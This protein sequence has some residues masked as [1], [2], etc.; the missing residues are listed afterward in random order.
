LRTKSGFAVCFTALLGLSTVCS[1]A[2]FTFEDKATGTPMPF[3]STVSGLTATVSGTGGACAIGFL[4]LTLQSGI[5]AI[6]NLCVTSAL[7]P[8][9]DM[10]FSQSLSAI[11][12]DFS[13][14]DTNAVTM[15]A[16]LGA[17]QIGSISLAGSIPGGHTFPEGI[18]SFNGGTF[19]NV[20][21]TSTSALSI[22]NVNTI[23]TPEPGSLLLLSGGLALLGLARRRRD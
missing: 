16:F 19:D 3:N 12:L 18:L 17:A 23:A 10:S 7:S 5:A 2:V 22:D 11:S 14:V 6:T 9:I 4:G 21:L 20:K 1:A 13:T 8:E 15:V